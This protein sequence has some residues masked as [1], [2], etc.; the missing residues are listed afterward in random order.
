MLWCTNNT[1]IYNKNYYFYCTAIYFTKLRFKQDYIEYITFPLN[2]C[3]SP[4]AILIKNNKHLKLVYYPKKYNRGG[5]AKF[6]EI[7]TN[8]AD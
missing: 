5:I 2:E 8:F 7:N 3:I 4:V 6:N 1:T